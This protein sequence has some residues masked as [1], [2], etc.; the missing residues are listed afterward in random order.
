MSVLGPPLPA[1]RRV[2]FFLIGRFI[3]LLVLLGFR[4]LLA[5]LASAPFFFSAG[6]LHSVGHRVHFNEGLKG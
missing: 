2:D 6:V 4:M 1:R 5:T 3:A